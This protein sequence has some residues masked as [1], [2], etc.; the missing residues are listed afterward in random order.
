MLVLAYVCLMCAACDLISI[1]LEGYISFNVIYILLTFSTS[2]TD[3]PNFDAEICGSVWRT[4]AH[5]QSS[6]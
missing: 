2:T 1:D 4:C 3:R 5:I 6:F